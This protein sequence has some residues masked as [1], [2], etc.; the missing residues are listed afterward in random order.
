MFCKKC[1]TEQK[2]GQKFC[3]KCGEPFL[4]ENG[5][6]YLKG[7]KKEMQDAKDKLASK[8]DELT[9]QGKKLVEEKVQPKLQE[10]I[11]EVK[12]TD[13][14]KKKDKASSLV[15]SLYRK[16]T[17]AGT[18]TKAIVIVCTF[19]LL[20]LLFGESKCSCIG[21]SLNESQQEEFINLLDDPS[22]AFTVRIDNA[23]GSNQFGVGWTEV[24]E[25]EGSKDNSYIWTL[26]FF[27]ENDSKITGRAVIEAWLIDRKA[28]AG[29]YT[30][31]YRYEIREG[32]IELYNGSYRPSFDEGWKRDKDI[33]LSIEK[34][35]NSF[36]LRG[37]FLRKER[38]FK[39]SQYIAA[40]DKNSHYINR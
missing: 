9:K 37:E 4:D 19:L 5:K 17:N 27:P 3:P 14:N 2:D 36:N 26:I 13:W 28:W 31:A 24:P 8:A 33:R 32:I 11:E 38:L 23:L 39:Q 21:A 22:T 34:E 6:P 7:L 16:F 35:G 18:K 15:H 10:T 20:F 1:G 30:K 12:N 40:P 29:T 25:G